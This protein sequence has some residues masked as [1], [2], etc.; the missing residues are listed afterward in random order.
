M[1]LGDLLGVLERGAVVGIEL[2]SIVGITPAMPNPPLTEMTSVVGATW[3]K[4]TATSC[5]LASSTPKSMASAE[6]ADPSVAIR[7]FFMWPPLESR[8]F[9]IAPSA[10]CSRPSSRGY[11]LTHVITIEQ[12]A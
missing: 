5:S 10:S 1:L 12:S 8:L 7:I 9:S 2:V 6:R 3:T 11:R 4:I